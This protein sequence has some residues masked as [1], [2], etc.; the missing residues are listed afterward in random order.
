MGPFRILS[1]VLILVIR[2]ASMFRI[3]GGKGDL[4]LFVVLPG[5]G[6]AWFLRG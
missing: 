6:S 1:V 2:K 5:A 3:A 4:C